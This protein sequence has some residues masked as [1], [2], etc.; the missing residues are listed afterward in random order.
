MNNVRQININIL[1]NAMVI[2][3]IYSKWEV[4]TL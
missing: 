2:V 1:I 4:N 3:I